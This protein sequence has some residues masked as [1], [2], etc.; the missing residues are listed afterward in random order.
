MRFFIQSAFLGFLVL[1]IIK[2]IFI[3]I[4]DYPRERKVKLSEDTID[5]IVNFAVLFWAG[6]LLW[7]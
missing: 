3:S 5:L 6:I 7:G 2:I 1:I 4:S